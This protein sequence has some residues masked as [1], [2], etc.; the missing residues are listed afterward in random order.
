[1]RFGRFEL[2]HLKYVSRTS[3]KLA[4]TA[5]RI[6]IIDSKIVIN[7]RIFIRKSFVFSPFKQVT[8]IKYLL[9]KKKRQFVF[10]SHLLSSKTSNRTHIKFRR[11]TRKQTTVILQH[12]VE[13]RLNSLRL[14]RQVDK[15]RSVVYVGAGS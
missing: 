13:L 14:K 2:P 12:P 1:M 4:K 7:L 8:A 11:K 3:G 15:R 10:Q 6:G 9:K 5:T